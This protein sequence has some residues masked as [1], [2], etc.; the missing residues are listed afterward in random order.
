MGSTGLKNGS[1]ASAFFYKH[2]VEIRRRSRLVFLSGSSLLLIACCVGM[3][4]VMRAAGDDG[5]PMSPNIVMMVAA[6]MGIYI[7]FFLNAT[8]EW[9]R[10]MTKPYIYLVPASPFLKLVWA[11]LTSLLKPLVDGTIA[12][13][14][15][16]VAAGA[17]PAVTVLCVLMYTTFGW[18]YTASNLL[19]EKLLGQMSNKGLIMVLYM[20]LLMLL[21]APGIIVGVVMGVLIPSMPQI[22]M[23]L[24]VIVWN[25]LLSLAGY[26]V[27][28]N[29]LHDME[30]SK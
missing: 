9:T 19:S 4:L 12:Y 28:R 8:G 21:V 6:M 26:A 18:V 15:C 13:I 27:C 24:P 5:E 14:L 20:L 1:G 30:A 2:L 17:G 29:T 23:A 11:S 22:L 7:Q 10:E 16:A 25:T 3:A